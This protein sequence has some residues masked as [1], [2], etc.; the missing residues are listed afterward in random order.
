MTTEIIISGKKYKF[1]RT[2][3]KSYGDKF[4][5]MVKL[6]Y[7]FDKLDSKFDG[8]IDRGNGT[9]VQARLALACKLMM[10]TG[11]RIGNESSAEGYTTKPHP[12]SK[13]EP[14]FVQTY[15]LTTML[16]QHVI[17]G[18]RKT[19]LNFI[20]KK[21][22]EN[23]FILTGKLAKRVNLLCRTAE[24]FETLFEISAY[25]LTKFIKTH[26]GVQFSP[27]DFRTMRANMY[28]YEK[29]EEISV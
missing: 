17:I 24:D 9:S 26:V 14:Q 2:I 20:G 10:H 7:Q 8:M 12:N 18:P 1:C 21:Q 5:R 23:S 25:E 6:A 28:A 4:N 3:G 29:Y 27:K 15:G 19:C 11:I 22:V 16:P 13:K